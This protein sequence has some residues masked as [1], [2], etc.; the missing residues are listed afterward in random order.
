LGVAQKATRPAKP[1]Q[2]AFA[3]LRATW[4]TDER[5]LRIDSAAFRAARHA[6]REASAAPFDRRRVAA[7]AGQIDKAA[8]TRS[9][10]VEIVGAQLKKPPGGGG[11]GGGGP[12]AAATQGSARWQA[13]PAQR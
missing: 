3:E 11:V 9:D 1:E 4:R 12:A 13:R 7:A 6:R 2:L 5:G 10:L 8:F